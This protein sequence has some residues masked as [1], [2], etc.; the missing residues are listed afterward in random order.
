MKPVVL[1]EKVS[2]V[3]RSFLGRRS[4]WAVRDLS[5]E[6]GPGEIFGLLGPNGSGKTTSIQM[7]MGLLEPTAGR[8]EVFGASP[9][10]RAVRRRLGYLPEE[11]AGQNFLSGEE[12]LLFYGGFFGLSRTEVKG[13]A[14]SLLKSLDLWD[15]RSRRLREYSKGMRRRIGLAQSLLHDPELIVLDEPTNGL[16]PLGIRTVKRML[17]ELKA[18]GRAL[19]ISSHVLGE[20]EGLCDRI[21]IIDRGSVLVTGRLPDLLV[22]P[23]CHR[24]KLRGK[25]PANEELSRDLAGKDLRI[26]SVEPDRASLEEFFLRTIDERRAGRQSE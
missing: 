7:L 1:I 15:D 26:E 8:I 10:S 18:R 13:R 20:M 3:F 23:D 4:V 17:L 24:I 11:F 21:A 22:R 14:E 2:R 25:I 5:L 12:N 6:V 19:I 16:D 9:R